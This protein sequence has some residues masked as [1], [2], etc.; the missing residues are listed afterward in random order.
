MAT[1]SY[2]ASGLMLYEGLLA[3]LEMVGFKVI[4]PTAPVFQVSIELCERAEQRSKR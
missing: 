4:V 1:G 3:Q 2:A